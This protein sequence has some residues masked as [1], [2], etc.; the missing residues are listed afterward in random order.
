[1]HRRGVR[2]VILAVLASQPMHG[3]QV[4]QELEARS[5]GRW[6]PSAG[7]VYPTLQQLEDEGLLHSEY[8]DGR[9]VYTITDQ[10]RTALAES[11]LG[12]IPLFDADGKWTKLNLRQDA[13]GLV[14]AA[15][16]VSRVGTPQ[17]QEKAREILVDA[18]KQM[19]RL[20]AEDDTETPYTDTANTGDKA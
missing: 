7:S 5:G 19:Y 20:L 11:P 9:R 8:V 2:T 1:M 10:G 15:I 4:M 3:Y 17:A 18:R 16:Q 13:M 14:G 6:R 12:G